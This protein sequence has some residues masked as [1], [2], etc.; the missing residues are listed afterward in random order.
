MIE[1]N[2]K[3][4]LLLMFMPENHN[5]IFQQHLPAFDIRFAVKVSSQHLKQRIG[6]TW[7]LLGVCFGPTKIFRQKFVS[8]GQVDR[9]T[10][11]FGY[12]Q[13]LACIDN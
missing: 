7:S 12:P 5:L 6:K 11:R 3:T 8:P 2:K 9:R 10:A 4:L 13:V 1:Q